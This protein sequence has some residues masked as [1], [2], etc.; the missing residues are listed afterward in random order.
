MSSARA[1][2]GTLGVPVPGLE[3]RQVV[4]V[5]YAEGPPCLDVLRPSIDQVLRE[6]TY[7]AEEQ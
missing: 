4:G 7:L 5:S 3:H 6:R 2:H 1:V